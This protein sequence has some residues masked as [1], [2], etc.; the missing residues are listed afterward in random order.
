CPRIDGRRVS[1]AAM[2]EHQGSWLDRAL[3]LQHRLDRDVPLVQALLPHTHNSANSTAYDPSVSTLDAN[4]VVTVTDQLDLGMRA[5]ELDVHWAP[6][7]EGDPA[8]GFRTVVQCHGQSVG[9]VHVG[10]S[11]DQPLGDR[12]AELAAWLD[13]NPGEVVLLYLENVLD[14][15]PA[16]HAEAVALLDE[17]VGRFVHRPEPGAGCQGLPAQTL[18]KGDVLDGGAQLVV[19]GNCGPS[20]WT[21]LVFDRYPH[22]TES[23]STTDYSCEADRSADYG[24]KLVRRYED[25]TW[26]ST[27]AGGGSYIAPEVMADM[28]ACGVNLP[29]FDQLH[30]GDPRLPSLVWSWRADEPEVD[31]T[32]RCAAQGADARFG[33]LDC[34]AELPVACRTPDGA[35]AV[36]AAAVSWSQADAAC[37]GEGLGSAGTPVNGWDNGQL[38]AVAGDADVWLAY[39]QDADG[40]WVLAGPGVPDDEPDPEPEPDLPGNGKGH[41]GKP[42]DPGP[43]AGAGGGG[44]GGKTLA[45]TPA[46]TSSAPVHPTLPFALVAA[47]AVIAVARTTRRTHP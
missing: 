32:G 20:G 33:A 9:G 40:S 17:H 14:D 29:G 6:H 25:S 12:L 18:S 24:T 4:Q 45:A 34:A 28:V 30:A 1:P 42:A 39:A 27:M 38:R 26:L 3:T 11:V 36:T 10:C 21:D 37:A 46:S 19:V 7:P 23:G 15:D 5:I 35:W 43:P 47:L 13:A 41:G 16:A 22:W 2:A 31:A 44:G 8:N